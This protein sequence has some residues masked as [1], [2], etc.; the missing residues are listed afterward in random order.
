MNSPAPKNAGYPEP[1]DGHDVPASAVCAERLY[2]IIG[3][4]P[5]PAELGEFVRVTRR[6][7]L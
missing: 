1:E 6:I 3:Q 2:R 7:D 4:R 5:G